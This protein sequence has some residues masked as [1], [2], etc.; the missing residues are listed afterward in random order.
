MVQ[1]GAAATSS[2]SVSIKIYNIE[3]RLVRKLELGKQEAGRYITK[4]KSAYWD[5]RDERGE[6]LASG[7]YWYT[8]QAGEFEATRRMLIVK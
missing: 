3:G 2:V 5:G 8:L 7:V 1:I 6:K 4:D